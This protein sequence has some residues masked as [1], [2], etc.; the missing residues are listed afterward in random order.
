MTDLGTRQTHFG[1]S[2]QRCLWGHQVSRGE[3][4][5]PPWGQRK[6]IR[7]V[8]CMASEG[9]RHPNRKWWQGGWG[10]GRR[11][12]RREKKGG[13]TS[14]CPTRDQGGWRVM[15]GPSAHPWALLKQPALFEMTGTSARVGS[16]GRAAGL[17][18]EGKVFGMK[19]PETP[20]SPPSP[21]T[22]LKHAS[23]F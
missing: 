7:S 15:A 14:L 6:R 19:S 21:I 2:L 5:V 13:A 18:A 23:W 3:C 1:K 16:L 12:E 10:K 8:F 9:H 20:L 11:E 4:S 17:S 22:L